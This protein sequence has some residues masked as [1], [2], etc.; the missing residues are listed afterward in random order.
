MEWLTL[1]WLD[2]V[3]LVVVGLSVVISLMRG[4]V[5]ESLSLTT[6]VLA[7]WLAIK[8]Y[9][10]LAEISPAVI[11]SEAIRNVAAFLLIFIVVLI[12]G[13]ILSYA[14]ARLVHKTG[15]S[16]TDRL[17]GGMFGFARGVFLMAVLLL[18]IELFDEPEPEQQQWLTASYL[19]GYF[20]PVTEWLIQRI[21][22]S[23]DQSSAL[24][25][26]QGQIDYTQ[27]DSFEF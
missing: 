5:R 27:P 9:L 1:N 26:E 14:V 6:W 25:L 15:L 19:A 20:L 18:V 11:Q 13:T 2:Y 17:L 4:L 3:I 23:L 21:P 12:V 22:Q 24:V 8:F 16:G 7:V 10:A